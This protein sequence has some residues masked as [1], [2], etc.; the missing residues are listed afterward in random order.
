[1][2]LGLFVQIGIILSGR[3]C[4]DEEIEISVFW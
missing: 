4:K 2:S 3:Y 1:M